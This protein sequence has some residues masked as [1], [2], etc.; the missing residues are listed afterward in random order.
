MEIKRHIQV[1]KLIKAGK[2]LVLYG[3]R[4]VGKT[5]LVE[6]M[7]ASIK[8]K[9]LLV[10]GED[11]RVQSVFSTNN[12]KLILE[13]V[14]SYETLIIDEAQ[15]IEN[16][17]RGLKI[18]IDNR[19]DLKI[20]ATGSSSFELSNQIGEPLV[21][22]KITLTLFSI[23]Q[24]ELQNHY[25]SYELKEQ[26][27]QFLIYG[28]YPEVIAQ[29]SKKARQELI[30]E[31]ANAYLFKDILAHQ[32]IK[33]SRKIREILQL[34]AFQIGSEVSLNEISNKVQLDVKTVDKYLDLLEKTF[35]I[36]SLSGFSRNLRSEVTQKRKYYFYDAGIRNAIIVNFNP[37]ALRN[38]IG[39]LWENFLFMERTKKNAYQNTLC[40]SYFW[41]TYNGNEID[42][43]EEANGILNGYEFKWANKQAKSPKKWTET[44]TNATFKTIN[45]T[46]YLDFVL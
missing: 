9:V 40:N 4:Q 23:A 13:F 15:A 11:Y 17:G 18:L 10:S 19:K 5:T 27:E 1:E 29:Q 44:Y 7:A 30:A 3:A 36:K 21:G 33:N 12:T 43:I 20:V 37:L 31:I 8:Q 35:V 32:N 46:N 2:V 6:K 22:R 42:L 16:I 25:N 39:A 28:T 14:E 34:L 38:D 26:L 45:K 24:L 41:R